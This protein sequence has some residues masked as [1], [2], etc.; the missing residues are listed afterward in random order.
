[1]A[2][3]TQSTDV[4]ANPKQADTSEEAPLKKN[5]SPKKTV[6]SDEKNNSR[7]FPRCD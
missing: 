1:M 6:A 2:V 7:Y 4:N 5:S 3:S